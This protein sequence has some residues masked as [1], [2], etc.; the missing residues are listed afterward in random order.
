MGPKHR[1]SSE[2]R[3][4]QGNFQAFYTVQWVA[5]GRELVYLAGDGVTLLS[6]G[7]SGGASISLSPPRVMCRLPGHIAYGVH[8]DGQ[9]VAVCASD[10]ADASFGVT[11]VTDWPALLERK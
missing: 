8:P 4:V 1:A 10:R 7:V 11:V 3:G 6:V 5:N 9:R 2:E